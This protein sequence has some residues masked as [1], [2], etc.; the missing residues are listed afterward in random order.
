MRMFMFYQNSRKS[1]FWLLWYALREPSY[2]TQA[3]ICYIEGQ[4]ADDRMEEGNKR[5]IERMRQRIYGHPL[6]E[7]IN[8]SPLD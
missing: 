1:R 4:L 7:K 8:K 6:K 5:Y 2:F 3:V